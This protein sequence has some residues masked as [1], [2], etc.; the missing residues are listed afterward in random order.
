MLVDNKYPNRGLTLSNLFQLLP[1]FVVCFVVPVHYYERVH[2]SHSHLFAERF[3]HFSTLKV[4]AVK[5]ISKK[6]VVLQKNWNL[7]IIEIFWISS[8]S[9]ILELV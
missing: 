6:W 8:T 9:Y 2:T 5:I 1:P 4:C 3:Y 7:Q